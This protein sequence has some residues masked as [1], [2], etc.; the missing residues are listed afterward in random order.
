VEAGA[1]HAAIATARHIIPENLSEIVSQ[2]SDLGV[3]TL[4][5]WGRN[6]R[7]TPLNLGERLSETLPSSFL[8]VLDGV[9]HIPHEEAPAEANAMIL[10][11]IS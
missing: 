2:Y 7:I 4:I 8:R 6:D 1:R 5:I 9:G 11:F 10:N 3:P